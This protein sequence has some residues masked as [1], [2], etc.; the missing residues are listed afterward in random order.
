M[1]ALW[2]AHHEERGSDGAVSPPMCAHRVVLHRCVVWEW[3]NPSE[4]AVTTCLTT[5]AR[6]RRAER[7]VKSDVLSV[8]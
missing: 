1:T 8:W 7:A 3:C 6:T 5:T 2:A 4:S